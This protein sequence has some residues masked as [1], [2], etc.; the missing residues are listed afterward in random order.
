[1]KG[2]A[3]GRFFVPITDYNLILRVFS[4]GFF[5][6]ILHNY[7]VFLCLICSSY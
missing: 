6:F 4:V 7:L 3:K 2:L 1:M 5:F